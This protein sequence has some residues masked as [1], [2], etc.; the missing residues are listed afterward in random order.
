[1]DKN[2]IEDYMEEWEPDAELY[3]NEQWEEL[4]NLRQK[5]AINNPHDLHAQYYLG[6]AYILNKKYE[7]AIL[8]MHEW[9]KKYPDNYDFNS[10]ILDSLI[11]LG[12]NE[13]DFEW[14]VK[15]NVIKISD[16]LINECYKYISKN[17]KVNDIHDLYD[18]IYNKYNEYNEYLIF[19]KEALLKVLQ[20]DKRFFVST[21]II[22][23]IKINRNNK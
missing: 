20:K 2:E 6:E 14:V 7:E 15:P 9:H 19:S 12:K 18:F 11:A 5:R 1:M 10:V 4:L 17:R 23:E 21:E 22:P 3:Y 13:D 16:E 8:F